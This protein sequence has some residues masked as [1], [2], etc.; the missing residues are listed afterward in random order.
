MP[1]TT[2]GVRIFEA[3]AYGIDVRQ[4][5][6]QG[7]MVLWSPRRDSSLAVILN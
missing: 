6:L 5:I 1:P 2:L 7:T 3:H 4:L